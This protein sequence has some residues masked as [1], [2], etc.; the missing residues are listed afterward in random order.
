MNTS[1]SPSETTPVK[2]E[3]VRISSPGTPFPLR[4]DQVLSQAY[5]KTVRTARNAILL[6][7]FVFILYWFK[8]FESYLICLALIHFFGALIF[9]CELAFG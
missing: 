3:M 8:F 7:L 6:I 1:N 2:P 5:A 9:T 4:Q